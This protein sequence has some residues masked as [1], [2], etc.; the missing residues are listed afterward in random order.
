[1][2]AEP[3]AHRFAGVL[4]DGSPDALE[5]DAVVDAQPATLR[6]EVLEDAHRRIGLED[7]RPCLLEGPPRKRLRT[8]SS[9]GDEKNSSK[10]S[11]GLQLSCTAQTA[12]MPSRRA[13]STP[14]SALTVS[15]RTALAEVAAATRAT[16]CSHCSYWTALGVGS[17]TT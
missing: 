17:P 7:D 1:M 15:A 14:Q 16:W 3:L 10:T 12:G 9:G 2:H 11:S 8:W 5:V 4:A 6:N 13:R